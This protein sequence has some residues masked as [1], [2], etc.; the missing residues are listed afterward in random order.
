MKCTGWLLLPLAIATAC[1]GEIG[2]TG[3]STIRPEP[4]VMMAPQV[5]R[6]TALQYANTVRQTFG[7]IFDSADFPIWGDDIPTIGFANDA[8]I[9]RVS[10]ANA[11]AL[12][13]GT[14]RLAERAAGQVPAL[15]QCASATT[16]TCF[17][18]IIDTVGAALWRRP[19]TADE[20]NDL[21]STVNGV[22]ASTTRAERVE[23]LVHVMLA[24]P[25]LLYRTELG[26]VVDARVPLGDYEIASALSYALWNGPPDQ[27]LLD[28]AA[29]GNLHDAAT[30]TA[31]AQRLSDDPRYVDALT[32][33][34]VDFMKFDALPRKDKLPALGLTPAVRAALIAGEREDLR[35]I[36][37]REGAS[38][39]DPFLSDTAHMNDITAPFFGM[40]ATG[41]ALQSVALSPN[42][43]HGILT[44][45]AYLS[46]HAGEGETGIVKRGVFTLE[47]LLCFH[48]GAPPDNVTPV[49]E[50]PAG[51]NPANE[52]SR[53]VLFVQH[54]SQAA[55]VGCHQ[56][57]DPAGYGYEN[58]D[59]AG[60]Y[61]VTE[62][63]ANIPIDASGELTVGDDEVLRFSDSV[64][65]AK[66]LGDSQT[67][68]NCI[69]ERFITYV[70]GTPPKDVERADFVT[71]VREENA[72]VKRLAEL[73]ATTP[74]FIAREVK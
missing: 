2:D 69:A 29:A 47:Q 38:L 27:T 14:S 64:E 63:A 17:G 22:A 1:T 46:V 71:A 26:S 57:I 11:E 49:T 21:L 44:H 15:T 37:R 72:D 25:H 39:I 5:R 24:S 55:C 10:D 54:T 73:I 62:K 34:Y 50:L 30:V 51:F 60:R 74:S 48:L 70:L 52:T 59:S 32:E 12:Y 42:E 9:L 7:D 35:A 6:L 66:V 8:R 13:S 19:L 68:R 23:L 61:R 20:R 43:R 67:V 33:F 45:P 53:H 65:Y 28:L 41:S 4:L 16:D 31:E 3:P 56:I 58:F 40:T 18:T 36:F